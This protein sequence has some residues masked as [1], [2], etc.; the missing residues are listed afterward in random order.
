M[1]RK[2]P[3]LLF[4]DAD[5]TLIDEEKHA[6]PPDAAEALRKARNNG[7]LVFLNTGRPFGHTAREYSTV[8]MCR[9]FGSRSF[10]S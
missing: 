10:L 8:W 4:F 9:N 6:V 1:I 3:A 5:G 2:K 7:H